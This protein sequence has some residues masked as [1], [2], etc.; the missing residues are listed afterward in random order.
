M[1]G[2][3][4]TMVYLH[5]GAAVGYRNLTGKSA[6]TAVSPTELPEALQ[7]LPP[8]Q[9]ED[10]LCIFSDSFVESSAKPAAGRCERKLTKHGGC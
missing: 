6:P 5:S 9:T 10:F 7:R 3:L 8:H 1:L 4:P 2:V